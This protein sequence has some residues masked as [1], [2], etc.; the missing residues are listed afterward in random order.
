MAPAARGAMDYSL[1]RVFREPSAPGL[2]TRTQQPHAHNTRAS[3]S[4]IRNPIIIA[5]HPQ[6]STASAPPHTQHTPRRAVS[7]TRP[8]ALSAA[9]RGAEL[10]HALKERGLSVEGTRDIGRGIGKPK[11]A[12][13]LASCIHRSLDGAKGMEGDTNLFVM[14][15]TWDTLRAFIGKERDLGEVVEAT[16]IGRAVA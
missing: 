14:G 16:S 2:P 6:Q 4:A 8:R 7:V 9:V 1:L 13:A 3:R 15:A 12:E 11:G 5:V 10:K